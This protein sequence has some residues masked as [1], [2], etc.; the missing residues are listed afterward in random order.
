MY[1]SEL[2]L[3]AFYDFNI[4]WIFTLR[5]GLGRNVL[6]PEIPMV[7]SEVDK[8]AINAVNEIKND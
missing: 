2:P 3:S 7:L 5:E 1:Q 4:V 6:L 8:E